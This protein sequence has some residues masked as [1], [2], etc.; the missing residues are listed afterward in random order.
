MVPNSVAKKKVHLEN[1][2]DY[3]EGYYTF[4]NIVRKKKPNEV[5]ALNFA[6]IGCH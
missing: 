3:T 6:G 5:K 1:L 2:F 4:Y